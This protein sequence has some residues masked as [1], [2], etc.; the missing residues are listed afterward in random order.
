VHGIGAQ[1]PGETLAKLATGLRRLDRAGVPTPLTDGV[2]ASIGGREVRVYEVYWAELH[3][4]T[5][6][7][8][9]FDMQEMQSLSWFPCFNWIRGCY[10]A[11]RYSTLRLTWWSVVL[12][13]T[14]FFILF[15]YWGSAPVAELV[16]SL[17]G[18][19]P[20]PERGRE[21]VV[22]NALDE[23]AGDVLSYVNSAGAAF[24]RE[25]KA[26]PVPAAREHLFADAMACFND[27]LI[28]AS[29][30]EGCTDI[31]VVAHS[32]GTVV[33]WHALSGFRLEADPATTA[34]I[35]A[36]RTKISRLYTIGCP[37]EKIRFFWPRITPR[38]AAAGL[39]FQWD[40]FVS[41]FDPVSGRVRTFDDWGDVKNHALLGGGFISA[42]VVYESSPIFLG[43]LGEG[44]CGH[45]L[46]LDDGGRQGF[47]NTMRLIGETLLVP[48]LLA[49]VLG[50]GAALFV[51]VALLLPWLASWIARIFVGPETYGPI[52]DKVS[53][54]L[55]GMMLLTFAVVPRN[56][57]SAVHRR[58]WTGL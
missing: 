47:R 37:L 30:A 12:P 45:P 49:L 43:T 17:L 6:A 11:A 1:D 23:Y 15:G 58:Y 20:T 56:R 53:L 54:V 35:D 27:R 44:L 29:A 50:I 46:S 34:A 19:A 26:A 33:T 4:G 55:L 48:I 5:K 14:N 3:K 2:T 25:K 52:V 10:R 7:H 31:Q 16:M 41:F 9:A 36:A 13:I 8:G 51:A 22:D 40:N 32:L 21:R 39:H 42:H 38:A 57:A 18:K 28:A 24:Y